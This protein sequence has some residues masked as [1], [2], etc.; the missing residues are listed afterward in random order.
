MDAQSKPSRIVGRGAASHH[1]NRFE[2]VHLEDDC[3]HLEHEEVPAERRVETVLLPDRSQTII[4]ENDS[5]DIPFRYSINPYR[6]CEHGCSYCQNNP[7][8]FLRFSRH[9]RQLR[10][11]PATFHDGSLQ[12]VM[13]LQGRLPYA[14]L[15][16]R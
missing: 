2:S 5:P 9:L 12:L 11:F 6:G 15:L 1:P 10:P 7:A 13:A 3:E 4:S 8:R 16:W 14:K